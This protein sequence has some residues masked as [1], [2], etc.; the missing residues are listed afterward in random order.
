MGVEID[1]GTAEEFE[2]QVR[3]EDQAF[4]ALVKDLGI[5]PQW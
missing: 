3:E 2:K 4:K 1:Y 5:T